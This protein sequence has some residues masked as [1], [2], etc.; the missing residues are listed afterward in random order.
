MGR[1]EKKKLGNRG[2]VKI[3]VMNLLLTILSPTT[4]RI[5]KW[6]S[7]WYFKGDEQCFCAEEGHLQI[8][9]ACVRACVCLSKHKRFTSS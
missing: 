4:R 2:A 7:Q 5:R 9:A 3:D 8:E 6:L 1:G